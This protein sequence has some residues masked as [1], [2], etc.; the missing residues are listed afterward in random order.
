[1]TRPADITCNF[2]RALLSPLTRRTCCFHL[3]PV[4]RD[5]SLALIADSK[6]EIPLRVPRVVTLNLLGSCPELRGQ[7]LVPPWH[8]TRGSNSRWS[9]T[10][11][12]LLSTALDES[13]G[14]ASKLSL[15]SEELPDLEL[16]VST[17]TVPEVE[18]VLRRIE[19]LTGPPDMEVRV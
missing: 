7:Q 11:L 6:S 14:Q 18:T 10:K 9:R 12:R 2:G 1:M 19:L 4:A 16:M 5:R 17:E 8:G 13:V 3:P 15:E